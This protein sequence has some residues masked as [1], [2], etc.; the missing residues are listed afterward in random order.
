MMSSDL[1][2]RYA[3]YRWTSATDGASAAEVHHLTGAG[4]GAAEPELYVKTAPVPHDGSPSELAGEADRLAWLAGRGIP[5]PRIVERGADDRLAWLVTEAVPG[6]P[7]ADEWPPEQRFAVAESLAD[8]AAALHGLPLADCPFD[9]GL[10][11]TMEQAARN[12]ADDLIDLDDLD[13]ERAGWSGQHLL[14][15]LHRTRPAAED[16]VVAHGDLT[17]ENVLLDPTT[18]R[19]TGVIDVVR[20]GR[21]DRHTDLAIALRELTHEEDP[22]FGPAHAE[23]FLRR[24]EERTAAGAD[25]IDD[26]KLAFYRL[27]DEFF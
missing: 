3:A 6:R 14:D 4:A 25:V 20:L 7:A 18:C 27:L 9:R 10:T 24:Y 11:V 21:A 17:P 12:V 23:R 16:P 8:L 1:R 2:R 22:W 5:V 13:D 19:V 26:R 15:E